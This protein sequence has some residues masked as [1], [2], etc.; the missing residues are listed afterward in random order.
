[1]PRSSPG[2]ITT[3]NDPAIA[4]DNPG[5]TLPST[6]ILTVHRSDSSGTS[7]NFTKYLAATAA[8]DWTFGHDKV[9]K[10]PGGEAEKGSDGV[11]GALAKEDGS[12]G[13]VE[14]SYAAVN[15]LTTAKIYNGA[16]EFTA[17]TNDSAG[18]TIASAKTS[19]ASDKTCSSPSTTTPRPRAPTRSSW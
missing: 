14:W 15:N 16:G 2:K 6:K 17:L 12:I 5:V 11:G 7:D 19:G 1:M 4:A 8:S 9:W 13:Y 3:W 10:A 18:K